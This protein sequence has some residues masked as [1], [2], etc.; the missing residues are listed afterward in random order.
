MIADNLNQYIMEKEAFYFA[1][2]LPERWLFLLALAGRIYYDFSGYTDIALGLAMMMG[3]KLPPNFNGPY[4]ASNIRDFWQR[5]HMSLSFWIRDYIYIPLGGS[6]HGLPRRILSGILAFA[7]CG[8]WH[9]ASWNFLFWGLYHG[10][11]LAINTVYRKLPW[12]SPLWKLY[13]KYPLTARLTTFLFVV[14]GWLPFFY[15]LDKAWSMFLMLFQFKG[16]SS[17]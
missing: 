8:L 15:P 10:L 16:I 2:D 5:W 7:L 11:G 6:Q 9:G 13:D 12:L 3:I 14:F 4:G 1:V 17:D